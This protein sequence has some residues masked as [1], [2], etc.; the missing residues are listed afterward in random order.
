MVWL[1]P[2]VGPTSKVQVQVEYNYIGRCLCLVETMYAIFR[3]EMYKTFKATI[4]VIKD[5]FLAP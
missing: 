3:I 1:L 4:W 5:I 2:P